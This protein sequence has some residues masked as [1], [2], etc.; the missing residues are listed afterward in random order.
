MS[1][2]SEIE[3]AFIDSYKVNGVFPSEEVALKVTQEVLNKGFL[4][5][6]Y[7][8]EHL[9]DIYSK[10]LLAL[11]KQINYH[12]F[13]EKTE[14]FCSGVLTENGGFDLWACAII[15]MGGKL[16]GIREERRKKRGEPRNYEQR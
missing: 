13:D 5:Q 6:E 9:E 15:Y 2:F 3:Q 11:R 10:D 16:E 4:W 7:T 14:A 8:R 12:T 1:R